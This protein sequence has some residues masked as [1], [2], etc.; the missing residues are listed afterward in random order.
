MTAFTDPLIRFSYS[1]LLVAL[2]LAVVIVVAMCRYPHLRT[3]VRLGRFGFFLE[4]DRPDSATEIGIGA[5]R[6]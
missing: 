5:P 3:A 1:A 2:M 6:S 4:A